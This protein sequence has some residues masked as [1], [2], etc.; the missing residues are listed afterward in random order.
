M[1]ILRKHRHISNSIKMILVRCRLGTST[2]IR[3]KA[4]SNIWM[5][6]GRSMK[7]WLASVVDPKTPINPLLMAQ[8]LRAGSSQNSSNSSNSSNTTTSRISTSQMTVSPWTVS[9]A[10]WTLPNSRTLSI[11]DRAPMGPR[12]ISSVPKC[13]GNKSRISITNLQ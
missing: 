1:R 8:I 6:W 7:S 13:K 3:K 2:K 12:A 9:I 10:P 4:L 5:I 11:L